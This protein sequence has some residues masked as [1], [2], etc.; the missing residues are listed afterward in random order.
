MCISPPVR[1][2]SCILSHVHV[3]I[4]CGLWPSGNTTCLFLTWYQS[5]RFFFSRA[6]RAVSDPISAPPCVFSFPAA[7]GP[8]A[9]LRP[10]FCCLPLKSIGR[11]VSAARPRPILVA[12]VLIRPPASAAAVHWT[13]S[14]PDS[15]ALDVV[16]CALDVVPVPRFHCLGRDCLGRGVPAL[17]RSPS[18]PSQWHAIA[19][20]D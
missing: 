14:V 18:L 11:P 5:Y 7:V 10:V 19:L 1:G 20:A 15:I 9:R 2:F 4:Y 13:W 17:T 6:T 3:T 16:S 8:S 12:S